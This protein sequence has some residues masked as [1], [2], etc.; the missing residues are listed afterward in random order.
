MGLL[1]GRHPPERTAAIRHE[2]ASLSCRVRQLFSGSRDS[3]A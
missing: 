2:C 3:S 1:F